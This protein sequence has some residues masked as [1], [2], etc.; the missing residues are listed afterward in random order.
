MI[1]T[2]EKTSSGWTLKADGAP[3][4]VKGA[5][6]RS[7][8]NR[9]AELGANA[10][11][12]PALNR[13]SLD[14][15]HSA[16]LAVLA[17]LRVRPERNGMDY[18]DVDA[19]EAQHNEIMSLVSELRDHPAILMWCI[20]NELDHIPGQ[21]TFNTKVWTAVNNIAREI[22]EIDPNHPTLT[23]VGMGRFGKVA[24][25]V[26]ACGDLDLIGINAY[27]NI[28]EVHGLLEEN[29][30]EKPYVFTEWGMSGM[31]QRP[32][33]PWGAAFEESTAAKAECYRRR[34][35][36]SILAY[37]DRCLGGFAFYWGWRHETTLSWYNTWGP[38][39][40]EMETVEVW[41][42]LWTDTP[43]DP[44]LPHL[45]GVRIN[46][47]IAPDPVYLDSKARVPIEAL[48]DENAELPGMRVDWEVRPEVEYGA[49]AGSGEVLPDV[50]PG[51]VAA[52]DGTKATL[53]AP[54]ELGAY[55][56]FAYVTDSKDRFATANL[57]FYVGGPRSA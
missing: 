47:Y 12:I 26:E 22:H 15:A 49:Y 7:R 31:W 11:R 34:Y 9:L 42:E 40:K 8:F 30:W 6:G 25:V 52:Q 36:T 28:D 39:G 53:T 20:G 45:Y 14:D 3:F 55:R 29:G 1:T 56:L 18:N 46:N 44:A 5:V 41:R 17:N 35:K 33:T 21:S 50:V 38:D 48:A 57:P 4:Y 37:P 10:V 51:C 32:K 24:G 43:A 27:A 16:G 23:A 54:A 2:L 13:E 19:V